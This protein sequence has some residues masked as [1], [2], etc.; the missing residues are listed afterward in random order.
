M[1]LTHEISFTFD[2]ALDRPRAEAFVRDAGSSLARADFLEDVTVV[3]CRDAPEASLVHAA[4]PVNAAMFG[5]QRLRFAS[6]IEPCPAG[7]RLVGLDIE[8]R[9][10][11]A[12]VSG[13]ARVAP[14]PNGS[15]VDYR[16]HIAIH[17]DL[18][19]PE[20]WGGK[21][22]LKMVEITAQG[23]L[24]RVTSRFPAAVREAARAHEA[25]FA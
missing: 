17:L 23:V 6:R 22:L 2:V 24:H 11:R 8:D 4:L 20:R 19:E 13:E 16:F 14:L 7:A 9:P 5:Q 15:R 3:P 18:P 12:R 25:T 21:A 10:G 1:E